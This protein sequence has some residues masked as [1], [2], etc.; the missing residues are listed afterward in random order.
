MANKLYEENAISDI[1][2]AIRSI[3]GKKDSYTVAEMG[4][5]IRATNRRV[6]KGTITETVVGNGVYAELAKDSFL[7]EHRAEENIFVRV[8][9]DVEPQAYTII[10]TWCCNEKNKG[11]IAGGG[12]QCCRRYNA[13][14][15]FSYSNPE[16]PV[17]SETAIG[18]GYVLITEDGELRVYSN[19]TANYS[20]RPSN[21]T[22]I[23]EY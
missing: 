7:A 22:V 10:D 16:G 15:D 3:N 20:I 11:L 9:F 2:N 17:A 18:I 23:V 8:K 4:S 12:Y 5:A 6:Y 1:A 14:L 21:Y 13:S 19:S